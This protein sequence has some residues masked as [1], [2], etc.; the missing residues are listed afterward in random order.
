MSPKIVLAIDSLKGC[1]TSTEAGMA[2]AQGVRKACPTCETIV[3]PVADGGEGLLEALI[4]A[5]KG[6]WVRLQAHGPLMEMRNTCYGLSEDGKTA[7]I[8][9]AR[10]SGLPLVPE[11][12]R[13]PLITTTYGTGE[14]IKD[15]LKRGC[16][17]ILIGLGG[18]A[19]NDAGMGLL[20]ALGYRFTDHNGQEVGLG[21]QALT[22]VEHMDAAQVMPEVKE[23]LFTAA[24]DVRNS[25]YGPEG[26]ACIFAPQKGA[27][28]EQVRTLDKGLRHF[29]RIIRKYTG[30]DVQLLPGSGAAGGM[31]GGLYALLQA[32]LRPGIEL[33][34]EATGFLAKIQGADFVITG[35]GK[36]DRQTL[37]GK[38]PAGVLKVA[39][40]MNIPVALL[41][42]QVEDAGLLLQAGFK[43]VHCI[44]P[45]GTPLPLALHPEFARAQLARTA[46]CLIRQYFPAS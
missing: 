23:A 10:I 19:T 24:C 9:M 11:G 30:K 1:L 3:F 25:F 34:L 45:P 36:S 46:E 18:S 15:A 44:N 26:A 12:Q 2:A 22:R 17:H 42:G 27:D 20:Q 38:V 35:E 5:T 37:M 7:F 43:C 31:G 28:R 39:R 13:S 14:L 16:R 33:I 21:G 6:T 29:S 32:D 8:E 41:A 4:N 40:Q